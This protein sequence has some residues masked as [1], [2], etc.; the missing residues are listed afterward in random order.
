MGTSI[1]TARD[2][3]DFAQG[4]DKA[5]ADDAAEFKR[6]DNRVA[7]LEATLRT[8]AD[9]PAWQSH[10]NYLYAREIAAAALRD[11]K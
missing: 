2:T 8:I 4:Y 5:A 10:T 1:G 9:L 3:D 6:L 11:K 7:E